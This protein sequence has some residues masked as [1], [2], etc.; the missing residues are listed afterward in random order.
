MS[1]F[2]KAFLADPQYKTTTHNP[3]IAHEKT[4]VVNCFSCL[5][6]APEQTFRTFLTFWPAAPRFQAL[7]RFPFIVHG[8]WFTAHGEARIAPINIYYE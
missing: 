4:S 1:V 6:R 5:T 8:S 3:L 7:S 2:S